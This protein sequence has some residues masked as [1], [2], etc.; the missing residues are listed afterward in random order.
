[1][2]FLPKSLRILLYRCDDARDANLLYVSSSCCSS[3][4]ACHRS[5]RP[6]MVRRSAQINSIE[7]RC[8]RDFGTSL[9]RRPLTTSVNHSA[10]DRSAQLVDFARAKLVVGCSDHDD[11]AYGKLAFMRASPDSG[12][13]LGWF[14]ARSKQAHNGLRNV[15]QR[16][17]LGVLLEGPSRIG[18]YFRPRSA[19]HDATGRNRL[20]GLCYSRVSRHIAGASSI[21]HLPPM[22]VARFT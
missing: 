13:Y 2:N 22:I 16:D 18:H 6:S 5:R 3:S 10:G 12:C 8:G 15:G 21:V 20:K 11:D 17:Y 9:N 14:N 19:T 4:C 1:M 7:I